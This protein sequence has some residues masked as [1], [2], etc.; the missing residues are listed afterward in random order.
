MDVE[1][2][3]RASNTSESESNNRIQV[4]VEIASGASCTLEVSMTGDFFN[5]SITDMNIV[6][7]ISPRRQW[8][9]SNRSTCRGSRVRH[10]VTSPSFLYSRIFLEIHCS[11]LLIW[12]LIW[13]S[14]LSP[15]SSAL[16]AWCQIVEEK[17]SS[18]LGRRQP[19]HWPRNRH[20]CPVSFFWQI[21]MY[22][23]WNILNMMWLNI[24]KLHNFLVSLWKGAKEKMIKYTWPWY[25][26]HCPP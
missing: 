26:A 20:Q 15:K 4:G 25:N 7:I 9:N 22:Y 8:D 18:G 19:C 10:W 6:A 24:A 17:R 3:S 21:T 23:N 16:H 5:I 14:T 13:P 1:I 2:A 12:M 11:F